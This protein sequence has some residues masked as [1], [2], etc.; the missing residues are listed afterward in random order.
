MS[1]K[2]SKRDAIIGT[3]SKQIEA[4]PFITLDGIEFHMDDAYICPLC[5]HVYAIAHDA[6]T[7]EHVPPESVGGK[8]I[9]VTCK[10]TIGSVSNSDH[11]LEKSGKIDEVMNSVDKVAKKASATLK[12]IADDVADI[13]KSEDAEQAADEEFKDEEEL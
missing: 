7:L 1:N 4:I 3:Y 10:A 2:R 6:L 5:Q 8:P 12:T 13:Y 11:E 9:L